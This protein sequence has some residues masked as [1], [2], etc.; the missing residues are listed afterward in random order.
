MTEDTNAAN[1]NE[2]AAT[3]RKPRQAKPITGFTIRKA[4]DQFNEL[5]RQG[6]N[7]GPACAALCPTARR[8]SAT[9]PP[10]RASSGWQ[11]KAVTASR[12]PLHWHALRRP[13][14]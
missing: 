9:T 14:C 5:C 3:G 1:V 4:F 12:W 13:C 10:P 11:G 8:W 6:R 7:A 2:A